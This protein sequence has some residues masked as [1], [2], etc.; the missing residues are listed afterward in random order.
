[1]NSFINL[2][3]VSALVRQHKA[4][5]FTLR[6]DIREPLFNFPEAEIFFEEGVT[7][8]DGLDLRAVYTLKTTV[9]HE[10]RSTNLPSD[11]YDMIF[12]VKVLHSELQA[13]HGAQSFLVKD[14]SVQVINQI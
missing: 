8:Q 12:Y 14:K 2:T 4:A 7:V 6:L 3:L 11:N 10:L 1:M 9:Y 13:G 5:V